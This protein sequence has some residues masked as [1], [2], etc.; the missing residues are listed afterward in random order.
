MPCSLVSVVATPV[1]SFYTII[2]VMIKVS[3]RDSNMTSA[4]FHCHF[5]KDECYIKCIFKHFIENTIFFC[6]DKLFFI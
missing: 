5:L 6:S 2:N 1:L 4:K 3:I